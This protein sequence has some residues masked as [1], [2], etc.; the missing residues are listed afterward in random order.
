MRKCLVTVVALIWIASLAP[1]AV[2]A[3][4]PS[5]ELAL[6]LKGFIR[7][8]GHIPVPPPEGQYEDACGAAI[9]PDGDI[10]I[11]DYYKRL[12]YVYD[13]SAEYLRQIP[14]EDPDGP[15]NLAFDAEE[16][17][18]V[19]N[20][21]RN[22]IRYTP[23][24]TT[25]VIDSNRSTGVAVDPAS[26]RI[27]VDDRTYI[28]VYEP[29]GSPVMVG[30]QPLKIGLGSLL[31][32]YGV[33]VSDFLLTEGDVYVPD[34]A[35]GV[36]RVYGP[37]G[38]ELAPIEGLGTPQ[39]GF[40]SLVDSNVLVTPGDGHIYVVDN[41]EP[42][43]EHP[44]AVV[45]E[46]N[47]AG[48]YRGQLP[49]ALVHAEPTA[50][51]LGPQGNVYAT[52]GNDEQAVLYGF[53]P[54]FPAHRLAVAVTGA[55]DGYVISGPSGINC[56]SAC[57]AEFNSGEEVTL[58]AVSE[59]GSAFVG[60]SGGGC[61]GKG[62]CHFTLGANITISAEFEVA[63]AALAGI[64]VPATGAPGRAAADPA[65]LAAPL[66]PRARPRAIQHHPHRHHHKRQKTHAERRSR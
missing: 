47:S 23:D 25:T 51:A 35:A 5:H 1:S 31:S 60:W 53:G 62:P 13:S 33:A 27:Y 46:F 34:A 50:L 11:S 24:G 41:T 39:Q 16:N 19:N 8:P 21:R 9:A 59:P 3:A 48:E 65:S 52:S 63:P 15:C 18:Y 54:T 22:V 40:V 42:G 29:D 58:T 49:H 38:E 17:L 66:A 28:A 55:G 12:I 6:I 30:G 61:S 20:W 37:G 56:G 57:A 45:D 43:F 64:A 44:A 26:G 14:I 2:S 32:G 10:Y 4:A 36:V 7:E